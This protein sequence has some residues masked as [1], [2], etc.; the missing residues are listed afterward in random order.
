MQHILQI[1]VSYWSVHH[2]ALLGLVGGSAGLWVIVQSFLHKFKIN[3]PVVSFIISHVF[4]LVTA[5]AAYVLDNVHPNVG[6]TYGWIWFAAQFWH[7]LI[8]NPAYDKYVIPFLDWLSKQKL[9][10]SL[11]AT[12][13]PAVA[14]TLPAASQSG[15]ELE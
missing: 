3:G 8:L 15:S 10:K 13:I 7:R 9:A 12:P 11:P 2:D 4:A 5:V 1:T 14:P 6:V